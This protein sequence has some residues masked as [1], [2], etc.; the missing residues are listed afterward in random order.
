MGKTRKMA[1]ETTAL[2]DIGGLQIEVLGD[3]N[4]R[5]WYARREAFEEANSVWYR[6]LHRFG[7][8]T[9]IDVGA[10][11]GLTSM[12]ALQKIPDVRVFAF[13][14][15]SRL[16]PLI[17]RNLQR[18]GNDRHQVVHAVVGDADGTTS[19]SLNPS[20]TLD[21]RVHREGWA[22]QTVPMGSLDTL[23]DRAAVEW[24]LYVKLDT[25][26]FELRVFR[27]MEGLLSAGS[28]W[29]VKT[30]FAPMWLESQDTAPADLLEYLVQ[31]Y[32]VYEAP[33][34]VQF[35][36]RNIE[37]CLQHPLTET[38]IPEFVDHVR[39]LNTDGRGWVDL[40]VVPG[41]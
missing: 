27:G 12:I 4:D 36:A 29:I 10:N 25:Q 11:Y 21:N 2:L 8:R 19:F 41:Q 15:D 38:A 28:D 37:D 31:R 24:P 20:S 7:V 18:C 14:A 16:I 3:L 22:Q 9:Y 40:L 34:R 17:R 30:E 33:S 6:L 26:G 13:E 39:S 23:V 32:R 1:E 5:D 35:A